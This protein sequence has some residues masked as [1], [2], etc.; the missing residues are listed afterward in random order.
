[1][2]EVRCER[3]VR[4]SK[5]SAEPRRLCGGALRQAAEPAECKARMEFGVVLGFGARQEARS[6]AL[7]SHQ[8]LLR[9]R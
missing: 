6:V 8:G 1:M 2:P 4:S 7:C 3:P 5:A 9:K